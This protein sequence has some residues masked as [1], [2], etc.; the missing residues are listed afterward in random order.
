MKS[1]WTICCL[2]RLANQRSTACTAPIDFQFIRT[3]DAVPIIAA[4]GFPVLQMRKRW[5]Y[6]PWFADAISRLDQPPSVRPGAKI[7][8]HG[9]R[10]EPLNV[11]VLEIG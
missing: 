9:A 6:F 2:G 1:H 10:V 7:G 11:R 5:C 8:F 4:S 3:L